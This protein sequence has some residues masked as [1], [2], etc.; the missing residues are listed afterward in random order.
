MKIKSLLAFYTVSAVVLGMLFTSTGCKKPTDDIG[1]DIGVV[2]GDISANYIDTLKVVAFTEREDT[3]RAD[4]TSLVP[5]GSFFD[6]YFGLTTSSVYM[7][8]ALTQS[9]GSGFTGFSSNPPGVKNQVDSVILRIRYANPTHFGDIGKY[10]GLVQVTVYRL[11]D[12]LSVLPTSGSAGYSSARNFNINPTPVGSATIIANPYDSVKVDGQNVAPHVRIKLKNSFGFKLLTEN[13]LAFASNEAFT[14]YFRG[15]YLKV[16]PATNFGAGGFLYLFPPGVGSGITI[17]Y[18][19]TSKINMI[20]NA[21]NSVWV[22]RH[23]NDFT[24]AIPPFQNLTGAVSGEQTLL[25]KP[26]TGTRVKLH[27]PYLKNF[28]ADKSKAVNKAELIF[29]V[30]DAFTGKYPVPELLFLARYDAQKDSLFN[31]VDFVQSQGANGGTYDSD[32]KEYKFNIT[33]HVQSILT[34]LTENDT[35]V[36]ETATKQTRGNRVALYGTDNLTKRVKLR[37]YYTNLQQ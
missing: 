4:R 26:L 16:T 27:I 11:L 6:P 23:E 8:F 37:L 15:L 10:Q 30:D 21:D 12:K 9:F 36:L 22:G 19:D 5:F 1:S 20:V 2:D 17:Y 31:L 18:N 13:P 7:N 34:G 25:I 28:G 35:L 33:L 29:P 32:K 24:Y 3:V 14:D